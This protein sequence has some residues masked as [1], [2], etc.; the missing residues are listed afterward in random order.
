MSSTEMVT[1]D[2]TIY[3]DTEKDW[4]WFWQ[5]IT[6]YKSGDYDIYAYDGNDNLLTSGYLRIN[7][8]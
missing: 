8:R 7:M 1:Y 3:Q 6:F 4:T 2:N 5:K